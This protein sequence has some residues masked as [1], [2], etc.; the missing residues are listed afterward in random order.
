MDYYVDN[1]Y[2]KTL[3][4]TVTFTNGFDVVTGVGTAFT[5]ECAVGGRIKLQSDDAG[6]DGANWATI[7]TIVDDEEIILAAGYQG[8]TGSGAA[9]YSAND[10]TSKDDAWV[11][12][13]DALE[14]SGYSGGDIIW[15]R[16]GQVHEF[17]ASHC[18]LA[19]SCGLDSAITF[20]ADDGTQWPGE[21]GFARPKLS[22]GTNNNAI[23]LKGR[24]FLR[25][26]DL[27]F[28]ANN[29]SSVVFNSGRD[30]V[31]VFDSCKFEQEGGGTSYGV[32]N[33]EY[34]GIVCVDCDFDLLGTPYGTENCLMRGGVAIRCTFDGGKYAARAGWLEDC[35]IGADSPPTVA[36]YRAGGAP[37]RYNRLLWRNITNYA[38]I[39]ME[40]AWYNYRG[41]RVSGSGYCIEDWDGSKGDW[42]WL[43]PS[44]CG[45]LETADASTTPAGQRSG[46]SAT[47]LKHVHDN[48][49]WHPDLMVRTTYLTE[50][51]IS[52][53]AGT[54]TVDVWIQPSGWSTPP[55]LNG[56]DAEIWVLVLAWDS[57][58]NRYEEYDS[59]DEVQ[60]AATNDTWCRIRVSDVVA[61]VD[62]TIRVQ[63]YQR[64]GDG[65]AIVYFDRIIDIL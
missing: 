3:T 4:G 57:T 25:F 30:G 43:G 64:K 58:N 61:D 32:G 52:V 26:Y 49:E 45:D 23:D 35:V 47:V 29:T 56:T 50:W 53:S 7:D 17:G 59:R 6:E 14:Y 36:A 42:F 11:H 28:H 33:F 15:F 22:Y 62:G 19:S 18:E 10:G 24:R 2:C 12:A 40:Q 1:K 9:S 37:A 8:S 27:H 20:R 38:A 13:R 63:V 46:G 54:Y 65:S 44:D 39:D 16:R 51:P 60:V 31:A 55:D 48:A 34:P 5:T 21:G 41:V